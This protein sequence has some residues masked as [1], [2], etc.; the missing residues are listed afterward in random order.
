MSS[1]LCGKGWWRCSE[2]GCAGCQHLSR[3]IVYLCAWR[4]NKDPKQK[5]LEKEVK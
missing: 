1:K 2:K 5:L 4:A 3:R